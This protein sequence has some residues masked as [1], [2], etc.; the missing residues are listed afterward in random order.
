MCEYLISFNY[1][2][3]LKNHIQDVQLRFATLPPPPKQQSYLLKISQPSS[4][5]IIPQLSKIRNLIAQALDV[6][7]TS[8]WTGDAHNGSFISGQLR[9]LLELIQEAK[10]LLKGDDSN[11]WWENPIDETIFDPP[12][13]P[14]LA[15]NLT[16][17][18]TSIVVTFRTLHINQSNTDGL[19]GLSIRQRLGL[20]ARL[21]EHDETDKVFK[22]KGKEVK[23]REKA[24]VESQDPSLIALMAKLSAL[25]HGVKVAKRALSVVMGMDD[26]D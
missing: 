17:W 15:L 14:N 23:V 2:L 22:F 11:K 9:L 12:L 4:P 20:A 6:I 13:P 10:Q 19:S 1:L 8:R 18:E 24:K 7:D 16:I 5:L 26:E 3:L 25:E 21:P